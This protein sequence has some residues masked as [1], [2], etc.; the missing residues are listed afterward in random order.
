M[1]RP[2]L[3][4]FLFIPGYFKN[5]A[6]S[7]GPAGQVGKRQLPSVFAAIEADCIAYPP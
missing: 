5:E 1:L 7:G 3:P 4:V 6:P 2:Y